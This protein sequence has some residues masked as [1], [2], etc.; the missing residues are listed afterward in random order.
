M[1]KVS[2]TAPTLIYSSLHTKSEALCNLVID[3]SIKDEYIEIQED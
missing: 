1:K 3:A 2:Y